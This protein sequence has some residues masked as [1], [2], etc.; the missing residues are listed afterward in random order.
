[1]IYVSGLKNAE[2]NG[3]NHAK[4]PLRRHQNN[5]K[6][7]LH[8]YLIIRDLAKSWSTLLR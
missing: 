8:D 1:M 2:L 5:L 4:G 3:A 7:R 6:H